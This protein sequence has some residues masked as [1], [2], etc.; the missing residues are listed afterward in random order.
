MNVLIIKLNATGDV[1]R[2]T[3][4]LRQ[5]EASVCWI[6]DPKNVSLL[7]GV[8]DGLEVFS[9]VE[10]FEVTERD[11]DLVINLEDDP[12]IAQF[13]MEL[14]CERVFGALMTKDGRLGYSDDASDWFDMSLISQ[15]GRARAD[16]LKLG[17]RRSY[18]ELLFSGLG[19]VFRG[20]HYLLPE[21]PPSDLRGDVA[22]APVAGAVWPMKNWAYYDDLIA[23]LDEK[24]L[25]VSV[26]P[27]RETLREHLADVRGHRC[28][29]SG[30]S[31]PMHLALGSGVPCV[32]LFTCTSPWEIHDYGLQEKLVSPLLGDYFYQRGYDERATKAIAVDDVLRAT[33]DALARHDRGGSVVAP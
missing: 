11:F 27:R 21:V 16:A 5:L 14:S 18:Q 17:N 23:T 12:D 10:R 26:L 9:W 28:L 4:L 25:S 7:E 32:S 30:D 22:L 15:Y 19:Y 8:F 29:V 13:A 33:L 6:T 3:P 31:L 2:T 1:V 20:E 24:G